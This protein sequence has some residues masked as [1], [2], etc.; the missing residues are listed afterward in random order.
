M[1]AS[2][3]APSEWALVVHGDG[4]WIDAKE[5]SRGWVLRWSTSRSTGRYGGHWP[6]WQCAKV[7]AVA[8]CTP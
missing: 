8:F 2:K 4:L 7:A 5:T 3:H 6:T 1:E